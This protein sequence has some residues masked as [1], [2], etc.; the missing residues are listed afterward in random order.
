MR[1]EPPQF[2]FGAHIKVAKSEQTFTE[3]DLPAV[4]LCNP[5]Y[6]HNIGAAVRGASV[7]GAKTVLF[8]GT[9]ALESLEVTA[10]DGKK[11]YR[12]PRE[13]RMKEYKDVTIWSDER[14]F[15]RFP[16]GTQ[17]VAVELTDGSEWL[18]IFRH[19]RLGVYVFGPEDGSIPQVYRR[20]CHRFVC[21]PAKSCF[22]LAVAV[23]IILYKRNEFFGVIK[24]EDIELLELL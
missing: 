8:T 10:N 11:G 6:P 3:D 16:R 19:P 17:F 1:E 15:D 23:N 20:H 7:C 13:E 12:L 24:T 5:K 22:N 21:I 18:P 9:R 14:P 4:I 2:E